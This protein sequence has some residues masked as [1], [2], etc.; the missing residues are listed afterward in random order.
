MKRHWRH[1][2]LMVAALL[3]A[4]GLLRSLILPS[5][6][7]PAP[8]PSELAR[9]GLRISGYRGLPQPQRPAWRTTAVAW[10]PTSRYRLVPM[11]HGLEPLQLELVVR[12]GRDAA[13]RAPAGLRGARGL[14]LTD[15]EQVSL[16]WLSHR[17]TLQTCLVGRGRGEPWPTAAMDPEDLRQAW[18]RW[19]ARLDHPDTA[20]GQLL[21][22]LKIQAGLRGTARWECLLVTLSLEPQAA[23]SSLQADRQL[24]G[25]WRRLRP[26][27]RSWGERWSD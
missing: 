5:T 12:R 15:R 27:L 18:R 16:G 23:R 8:L 17:P 2:A 9:A 21:R 26:Q 25:A 13:S 6:P 1:P 22:T 10:G 4:L 3:A 19:H 11:A 14:R 24:I 20:R 7:A